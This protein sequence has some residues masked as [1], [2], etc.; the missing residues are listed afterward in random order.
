LLP[1]Q[2]NKRE[3][4]IWFPLNSFFDDCGTLGVRLSASTAIVVLLG[5]LGLGFVSDMSSASACAEGLRNV[6]I[7]AGRPCLLFF[8]AE[9]I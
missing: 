4:W 6:I 8:S 1:I 3:G 2:G 9:C 5:L 7:T